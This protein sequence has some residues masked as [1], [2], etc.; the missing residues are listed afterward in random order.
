VLTP[1]EWV[2][3]VTATRVIETIR[4]EEPKPLFDLLQHNYFEENRKSQIGYFFDKSRTQLGKQSI[5][6]RL[7]FM[8]IITD[9]RNNKY[10]RV[11]NDQV[12]VIGKRAFFDDY[13]EKV[14]VLN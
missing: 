11:S 1:H 4:V 3:Y 12:R 13:T 8:C 9:L 10:Q 2:R 5:Q 14:I 6:N 7:M